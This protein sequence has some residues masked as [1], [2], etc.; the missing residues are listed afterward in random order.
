MYRQLIAICSQIH[1]KH[2]NSLREQNVGLLN[3]GPGGTLQE[4]NKQNPKRDIGT[5]V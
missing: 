1:T 2:I 3:V 5:A 4:F